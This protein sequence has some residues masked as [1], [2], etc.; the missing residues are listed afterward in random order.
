M[1]EFAAMDSNWGAS[2]KLMYVEH[3]YFLTKYLQ[4]S[5]WGYFEERK[6][7]LDNLLDILTENHRSYI[8]LN[9]NEF[10]HNALSYKSCFVWFFFKSTK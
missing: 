4:F 2:L 9:D 1:G 10:A 7:F 8:K 5:C 3:E 6:D